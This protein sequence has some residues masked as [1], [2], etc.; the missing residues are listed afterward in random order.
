MNSIWKIARAMV[1]AVTEPC[2]ADDAERKSD[3][4]GSAS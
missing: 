1:L 2:A 3:G 4:I